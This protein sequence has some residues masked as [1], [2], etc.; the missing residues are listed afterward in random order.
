ME[1]RRLPAASGGPDG[2]PCTP[3]LRAQLRSARGVVEGE[4]VDRPFDEPPP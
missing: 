1:R 2:W 4:F 3:A